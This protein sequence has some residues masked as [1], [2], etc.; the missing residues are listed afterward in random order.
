MIYQSS[1][2]ARQAAALEAK[3]TMVGSLYRAVRGRDDAC[4]AA[5]Q[6]KSQREDRLADLATAVCVFANALHNLG[7]TQA[8]AMAEVVQT[9]SVPFARH[10]R[11]SLIGLARACCA[12]VYEAPT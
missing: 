4:V 12:V 9:I 3:D 2:L 7:V 5:G 10:H 11:C 8:D 1:H 6:R